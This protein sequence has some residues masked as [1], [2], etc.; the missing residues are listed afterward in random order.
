MKLLNTPILFSDSGLDS[1]LAKCFKKKKY[2]GFLLEPERSYNYKIF[3]KTSLKLEKKKIIYFP[4]SSSAQPGFLKKVY[5]SGVFNDFVKTKVAD[6][7]ELTFEE[8]FSEFLIIL[9]AVLPHEKPLSLVNNKLV[10]SSKKDISRDQT[11]KKLTRASNLEQKISFSYAMG[12]FEGHVIPKVFRELTIK[13]IRLRDN[14][15]FCLDDGILKSFTIR[16]MELKDCLELAEITLE[17]KEGG[18]L[19]S[20][21]HVWPGVSYGNYAPM[22][23][24]PIKPARKPRRKDDTRK[25]I[26]ETIQKEPDLSTLEATK[27]GASNI[28]ELSKEHESSRSFTPNDLM[29]ISEL[30][31]PNVLLGREVE[32]Q[33]SSKCKVVLEVKSIV[34]DEE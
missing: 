23:M 7:P 24:E 14:L 12:A 33:I 19:I 10:L 13:E 34:V 20:W 22:A 21:T 18:L 31:D 27:D 5:N 16:R 4:Y 3:L 1:K 6:N 28:L 2:S 25:K 30:L 32:L 8:F 15:V 26:A 9:E 29:L 11:V 17:N